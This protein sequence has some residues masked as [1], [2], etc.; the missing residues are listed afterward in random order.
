MNKHRLISLVAALLIGASTAQADY[1]SDLM[2]SGLSSLQARVIAGQIGSGPTLGTL[3]VTGATTLTG[4]VTL[5]S[6]LG[7]TGATTLSST[8]AVTGTS[9]LTGAVT[10]ASTLA[11]DDGT[12]SL[13]IR[14]TSH[15][16][17]L[18]ADDTGFIFEI[19]GT[20]ELVLTP[21]SVAPATTNGLTLGGAS[22]RFGA[23]YIGDGSDTMTLDFASSYG[24]IG[25]DDVGL[26]I[27][28]GGTDSYVFTAASMSFPNNHAFLAPNGTTLP[29][30]C[31]VG[32]YF[33]DTDSDDCADTGSGDGAICV[34]KATNT[35]A[36]VANI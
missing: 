16:A 27:E 8:L 28:I 33:Q 32:S 35:W 4:A 6:T 21:S 14:M 10:A 13:T 11:V 3:S 34:C 9:T 12:D 23:V 5:G 2:G 30:T 31:T 1:T 24:Q 17:E 22:N 7:V 25:V 20:D 18:D 29:A 15:Y 19:G 26:I 36:L